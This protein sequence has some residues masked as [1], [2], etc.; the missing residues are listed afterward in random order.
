[1]TFKLQI[2]NMKYS[3]KFPHRN[4]LL[5]HFFRIGIRLPI[6]L[7]FFVFCNNLVNAQ[8]RLYL[9]ND[10]HTDYIASADVITYDS[11]FVHMIDAWIANNNATNGNP[12]DYQ[13]KFNC[14]GS[15]WAWVYEK[16]R[17][18]DQFQTFINQVRSERIIVPMNPLVITYGCVPTEATLRG[19]YYAGE[20]ERKYN[21]KFDIAQSMEN[22]VLPLGL[23][24]LWKGSGAKY[25][26]HGVCACATYV[27][28]LNSNREKQ[29][30]WYKGLDDSSVL[31]KWYNHIGPSSLGGYAEA[32]DPTSAISYLTD[33]VNT[34]DYNYNIAA[35]FG[36]GGDA[37]QT[38]TDHL[39]TAAQSASNSSR[40]VI[41]SN[42]LDFFRDFESNYGATLPSLTQS[43]GN[44]WEHGCTSLAE[45]SANIKR[46]LEKLRSAEAMA[47]I[48]A[49]TNP[50]FAKALDSL[51][52]EAWMAVG[53]YWE[54]DFGGLT[55]ERIAWE[56]RQQQT[57]S[58]YVNQLYD[59]AKAN[60]ANQVKKVSANQRFFVFNPLGW[61]RTDYTDFAYSGTLP[62]HVMDVTA[63]TEAKSQVVNI[64]GTQYLRILA[65]NIPSVGYKVFEIINGA[66]ASFPN[67]GSLNSTSQTIDNDYFTIV[68]T[69]NGVITSLVDKTNGNKE[70]VNTDSDSSYINNISQSSTFDTTFTGSDNANGSFT[71]ESNGPVSMSVKMTSTATVNHETLLTVFKDIPRIEIDNKITENFINHFLYS[72]FSFNNT[73]ISS[74]TIWHEENGAVINAKKVSS[75]GHYADQQARYDWLTLN[76]FA[77]VSSN[78]NY[79]I[80]L[81]NQDCYFME[82]GRS[83]IQTLDENT[84]R[85][86]VLIGGP[87]DGYGK[88][89]QNN[90]T[91]FNQRYA[92]STYNAYSAAN[93][94]KSAFEHQNSLVSAE[95]TNTSGNL[96]E[97][98][99]SFITIDDPNTVLW[100][101]KPAEEGMNS[102]GAVV[103]VWNLANTSVNTNFIFNDH[104]TEA[105]NITHVETDISDASFSNKTLN[106]LVGKSQLKSFRVKLID[107][108]PLP[109]SLIEFTGMKQNDINKLHWQSVEGMNFSYYTIERSEDG[110]TFDSIAVIDGN[111]NS[112]YEYDDNNIDEIKPYY[113]RLKMVDKDGSFTYSSVILIAVAN[114][115]KDILVY[116]NPA[117]DQ[118]KFQLMLKKK[119]RY[120]VLINDISGKT[121]M[122][123][124]PP[125]FEVG[126]NYFTINTSSLPM[127]TYTLIVQNAENKYIRKFIKH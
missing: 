15:Y 42:E 59:L 5:K 45:P 56:I 90:E 60:L 27:P 105:K 50:S 124:P 73:S 22:Q 91:E 13:T 80:T 64:N 126:N 26:W 79:G 2:N 117:H 100:A 38:T 83:N 21:L 31:M 94:M 88:V 25:A 92:I 127:G 55:D 41:V 14:D 125:L 122:K 107:S 65:S 23:P 101:L 57:F 53:L 81:S 87:I 75:G 71:L 8:S 103:R 62:V 37:L 18:P 76:H 120:D 52:K 109:I 78:G 12:P 43:Y 104:I 123:L 70:L 32:A 10:D 17:T 95:I 72:I 114:H 44:E 58:S 84:A 35:A 115:V 99:F 93:S 113:Y 74:P 30:Y 89:N 118:L 82:T 110:N 116:P 61:T 63:N 6:F 36:F 40:R 7:I 47:T 4:I 11:A 77:A 54:H 97:N 86:K 24:S 51:R 29:I 48:V 66:G 112:Q 98:N 1:M 46:S 67:A 111:G 119:S 85:I 69:N 3:R 16:C 108:S 121:I 20:L 33:K 68:F 106:T 9:S 96:P 28:D 19:M 34:P 39:A 49:R 102:K